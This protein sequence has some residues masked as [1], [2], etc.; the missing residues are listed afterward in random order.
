MPTIKD[1]AKRANVSVATVSR[2][3]NNTGYV[4]VETRKLVEV[5]IDELGY[6]PNELARSLFLKKSNIIGLVVPHFSTYY[7]AELIQVLES[8]VVKNGYNLMVFN[9][10][11]G[12]VEKERSII[13]IFSQ[14]NIDGL[15]LVV[16]T[17]IIDEYLKINK[18]IISVDRTLRSDI[19]SV[20]CDNF[21]GG[22]I[23]AEKLINLQCKNIAHITG[24]NHLETVLEREAGFRQVLD[25]HN[26]SYK[27]V[28][29]DF[30]KPKHDRIKEFLQEEGPFD[31]IFCSSDSIAAHVI[32]VAN[33]L[34][35]NLPKD[36]K[37]IGYDNVSLCN[38]TTP[39]LSTIRQPLDKLGEHAVSAL[40]KMITKK[41][42]DE[43][44]KIVNVE[45]IERN[46]TK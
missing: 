23:A 31:G 33:K 9:T 11:E 22:R 3:I 45:F 44:H 34:D 5:A 43:P 6:V 42:V 25:K 4:N 19:P 17:D 38:F 14:Y 8:E 18:P 35:Y 29:V 37:I 2:V 16:D 12:S 36:M 28:D 7:F 24:P 32:H 40:I 20:Y 26:L 10:N 1:V 41:Q 46:S 39:T 30:T 15:I 21:L 27:S 13:K